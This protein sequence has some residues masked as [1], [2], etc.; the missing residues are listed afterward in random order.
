MKSWLIK[1]CESGGSSAQQVLG[2]G[3]CCCRKGTA[4]CGSFYRG[5]PS[6]TLVQIVPIP[7]LLVSD[8]HLRLSLV[9]RPYG[10]FLEENLRFSKKTAAENEHGMVCRNRNFVNAWILDSISCSRTSETRTSH[11]TRFLHPDVRLL[12]S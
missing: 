2:F 8:V 4:C 5:F 11:E 9:I 3:H 12:H 7:T 6:K 10:I 1:I